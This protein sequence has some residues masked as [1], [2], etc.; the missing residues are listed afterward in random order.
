[1]STPAATAA[2][3]LRV[4]LVEDDPMVRQLLQMV[5]EDFELTL[6]SCTRVSEAVPVLRQGPA[7]LI[8]T[9]LVS[10]QHFVLP[11]PAMASGFVTG[12]RPSSTSET[13]PSSR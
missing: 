2:Q 12:L 1:M 5:W 13:G 4:V 8:V 3:P 7:D 9:D 10:W 11:Q 6:V